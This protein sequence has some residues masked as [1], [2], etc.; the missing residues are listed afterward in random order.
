MNTT[1]KTRQNLCRIGVF[2][3]ELAEMLDKKGVAKEEKQ[4]YEQIEGNYLLWQDCPG[5]QGSTCL[6]ECSVLMLMY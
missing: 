1:K 6:W 2:T 4:I 5:Q 3:D